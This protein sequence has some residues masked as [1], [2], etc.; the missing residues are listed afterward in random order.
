MLTAENMAASYRMP[1]VRMLEGSGGGGSVRT[2][3]K[4]GRA[5]IP[6]GVGTSVG[7][8][9]CVA[10]LSIVPVV[11]LGLGSVAGLAATRLALSHYSVMAKS[12]SAVFIAGPPVVEALGETRTKENRR[13]E[14]ADSRGFQSDHAVDTEKKRRRLRRRFLSYF[15]R[16]RY[17]SCRRA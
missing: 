3:E 2:I 10:N 1:I 16:A 12:M 7:M 5:N 4:T 11:A 15:R 17:G 8:H 9:L 14:S 6:N 13:L